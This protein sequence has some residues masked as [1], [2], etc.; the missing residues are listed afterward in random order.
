MC[1]SSLDSVLG[2]ASLSPDDIMKSSGHGIN[3]VLQVHRHEVSIALGFTEF[4][5][6]SFIKKSCSILKFFPCLGL[7]FVLMLSIFHPPET[8]PLR[9]AFL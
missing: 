2:G 7:A 3:Q 6:A 4:V 1:I 5:I 8:N 9:Q